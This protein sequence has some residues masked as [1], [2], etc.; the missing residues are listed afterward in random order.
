MSLNSTL[1]FGNSRWVYRLV[2]LLCFGFNKVPVIFIS[3][4]DDEQA[5][6]HIWMMNLYVIFIL[7]RFYFC[8]LQKLKIERPNK[9]KWFHPFETKSGNQWLN[10][11]KTYS[12]WNLWSHNWWIP[13][14]L[15]K[16]G[17]LLVFI[18]IYVPMKNPNT[19][20]CVLCLKYPMYSEGFTYK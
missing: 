17:D 13:W 6:L 4:M 2:M 11:C 18:V 8:S 20:V 16:S 10:W 14:A 7:T 5:H 9:I 19:N 1:A 15:L 3:A 12:P